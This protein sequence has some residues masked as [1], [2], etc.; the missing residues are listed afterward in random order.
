MP[1]IRHRRIINRKRRSDPF[2]LTQKDQM[3]NHLR[4]SRFPSKTRFQS[5]SPP[6][7]V[8]YSHL[9]IV[10]NRSRDGLVPKDLFVNHIRPIVSF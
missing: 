7:D 3:L 4:T 8:S 10:Y 5:S 1:H 6:K 2:G 9:T